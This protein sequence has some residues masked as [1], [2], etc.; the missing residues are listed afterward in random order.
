MSG[1]DWRFYLNEEGKILNL[2][3]TAASALLVLEETWVLADVPG[4]L[5]D[6]A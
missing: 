3:H 1:D 5:I 2:V 4:H 6:L